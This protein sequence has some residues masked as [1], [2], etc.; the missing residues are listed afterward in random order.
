MAYIVVCAVKKLLTHSLRGRRNGGCRGAVTLVLLKSLHY[1]AGN[2]LEKPMLLC[3]FKKT[4]KPQN[5]K[6]LVFRL[7][8][9]CVIYNTNRI[10]HILIVIFE[11]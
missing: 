7:F 11:F 9:C 5:S 10:F 8:T 4:Y 3:F 6:F 1:T 2:G